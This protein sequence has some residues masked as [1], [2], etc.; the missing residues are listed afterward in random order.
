MTAILLVTILFLPR[1]KLNLQPQSL[2]SV[3]ATR[4]SFGVVLWEL[5][6]GREPWAGF[7]PLQ[8]MHMVA[9]MGKRLLIPEVLPH[10][11][12][13]AG[14]HDSLSHMARHTPS[15]CNLSPQAAPRTYRL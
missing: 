1:E 15:L 11:A 2:Y 5:L 6:T 8:I 12:L 4:Y 10:G 7:K 9:Q 14:V 13:A 3:C